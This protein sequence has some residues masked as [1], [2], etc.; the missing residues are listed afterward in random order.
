MSRTMIAGLIAALGMAFAAGTRTAGEAKAA[1]A[2]LATASM[3]AP[4]ANE[5]EQLRQDIRDLRNEIRELN[6]RLSHVEGKL[7]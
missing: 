6:T 3:L 2:E 7:R 5:I 1:P 4:S